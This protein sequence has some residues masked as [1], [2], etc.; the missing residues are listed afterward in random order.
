MKLVEIR[1]ADLSAGVRALRGG[2][3]ALAMVRRLLPFA[4]F[5]DGSGS[6]RDLEIRDAITTLFARPGEERFDPMRYR[7]PATRNEHVALVATVLQAARG[8]RRMDEDSTIWVPELTA[9]A[10]VDSSYVRRLAREGVLSRAPSP[11]E[12]RGSHTRAPIAAT[13]A[14]AF[15]RERG[16]KPWC[17]DEATS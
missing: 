5:G 7:F 13:S 8:R 6:L 15:L 12:H 16:V 17:Y 9:L 4:Q 2:S 1:P 11:R 10:G 3:E 14:Q